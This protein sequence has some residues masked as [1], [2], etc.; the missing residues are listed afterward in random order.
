MLLRVNHE[1]ENIMDA[2][3]QSQ[4]GTESGGLRGARAWFA[5]K[6]LVRRREQRVFTGV[7]GAF[8]RRYEIDPFVARVVTFAAMIGLTPLP[9]LALWILMP[10][11]D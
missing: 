7:T 6:G 5:G 11:E 1:G 4:T 8:A 10:F 9:Y 3:T 2:T